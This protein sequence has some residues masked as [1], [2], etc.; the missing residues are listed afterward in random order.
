MQSIIM[1]TSMVHTRFAGKD[2][3]KLSKKKS[4]ITMKKRGLQVVE[5]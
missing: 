1:N 5:F 4:F 3:K 2:I